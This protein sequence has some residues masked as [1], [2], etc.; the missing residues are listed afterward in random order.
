MAR[1]CGLVLALVLINGLDIGW[2]SATAEVHLA[3]GLAHKDWDGSAFALFILGALALRF[4]R[5]HRALLRQQ[6]ANR[7][8]AEQLHKQTHGAPIRGKGHVLGR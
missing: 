6:H 1:T 2:L 7:G 5:K 3:G 8:L 4:V